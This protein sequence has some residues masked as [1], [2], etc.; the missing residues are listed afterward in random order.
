MA[1]RLLGIGIAAAFLVL[2]AYLPAAVALYLWTDEKGTIHITDYPKPGSRPAD[3]EQ[4]EAPAK[5]PVKKE[6]PSSGIKSGTSQTTA[7]PV[8]QTMPPSAPVPAATAAAA[9][10]A[11]A[12]KPAGGAVPISIQ[13]PKQTPISMPSKTIQPS[14]IPTQQPK[15]AAVSMPSNTVQPSPMPIQQL[16]QAPASAPLQAGQPAPPPAS[17]PALKQEAPEAGALAALVAGFLT[18]F[19]IVL[20]GIYI[21][22]CLCLFLI[23]KKLEVPTAWMAWIPILQV[24]P[25]LRSA[26]KPLWWFLL[27]FIPIVSLFVGVYLWMCIAENLGKNK[28]LGVLMILPIVNFI[29]MGMLAFSKKEGGMALSPA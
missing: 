13:Q 21:F 6:A 5:A 19:L 1:R 9:Q 8:Q 15:Q 28:M 27:F 23:A 20:A 25:F 14:P 16:K 26:G 29:V 22:T 4:L 11:K 7:Q 3:Q 17:I 24:S 10:D 12:G 2:F 18:I